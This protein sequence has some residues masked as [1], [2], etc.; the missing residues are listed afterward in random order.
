M[1]DP[2]GVA[3]I[4]EASSHRPVCRCPEGWGGNPHVQCFDCK[5][6][7]AFNTLFANCSHICPNFV[8]ECRVDRDC[9]L[10]KAC[11]ANECIDPCRDIRCGSRAECKV[12]S[13]RATCY[14]PAG[15]QGNPLVS[16][17]E[18]GCR[19]SSECADNEKC[20]NRECQR[21]CT[22]S[23]C[24]AGAS[25]TARNHQE[26]CTCDPPLQGDGFSYCFTPERKMNFT[27]KLRI[28]SKSKGLF[29]FLQLLLMS[30]SVKSTETVAPSLHA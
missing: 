3:A 27:Q 5:F 7:S 13:H 2:C 15:L 1:S 6:L 23:P 18:V 21:L 12:N 17:T 10:T 28:S 20:Q 19:A 4:C 25:C 24:A 11:V 8:D 26:I 16:C 14:C 30:Q 22:S 9:P 29:L